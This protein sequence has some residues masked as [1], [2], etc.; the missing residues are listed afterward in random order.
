MA[1]KWLPDQPEPPHELLDKLLTGSFP[2]IGDE[3]D[4]EAAEKIRTL[5]QLATVVA[6][7]MGT[8]LAR[9][10][11][12]LLYGPGADNGKSQFLEA[13][14]H[15]V[16]E[17]ARISMTLS[18]IAGWGSSFHRPNLVGKVLNASGECP[19]AVDFQSDTFKNAIDGEP[20][21]GRGQGRRAQEFRPVAQHVFAANLLP[22]L[23]VVDEGVRKRLLIICFNRTIPL[24]E[25]E[26]DLGERI[27]TEEPDALLAWAVEGARE[28]FA[29]GMKMAEPSSSREEV[30]RLCQLSDPVIAFA[31][32]RVCKE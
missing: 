25:Q 11:A 9:K 21:R 13:Y 12:V 10:K 6:M 30:D 3:A 1:G 16:P 4:P 31:A 27:A 18:D 7:G 28:L 24:R 5:R 26:R 20:L 32:D 14:R 8:R 15:L 22:V 29:N 17:G 2:E 23:G 19:R